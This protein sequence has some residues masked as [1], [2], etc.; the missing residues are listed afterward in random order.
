M[1]RLNRTASWPLSTEKLTRGCS[2]NFKSNFQPCS[3]A[4]LSS[5]KTDK[6]KARVI[7]P[8]SFANLKALF[9]CKI[10]LFSSSEPFQMVLRCSSAS[11]LLCSSLCFMVL[12]C[13]DVRK[14]T[15][16]GPDP[17][18]Q[19][20]HRSV[21]TILTAAKVRRR[22]WRSHQTPNKICEPRGR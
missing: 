13:R 14:V 6:S 15:R 12:R 5:F 9:S 16:T 10:V 17:R 3:M 18:D 11:W 20:A 1:S 4:L 8:R 7:W 19:G 21:T 2:P 22:V